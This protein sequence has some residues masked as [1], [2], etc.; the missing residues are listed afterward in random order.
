MPINPKI[1]QIEGKVQ[2][3]DWGGNE[4]IPNLLGL[5]NE[6]RQPFAEYWLGT[7]PSAMSICFDGNTKMALDQYS[8]IPYLFKILDV[9]AMLSIQVHPSKNEAELGFELEN[10][11]GIE[12]TANH[13]NYKD[14]NHKPEMAIAISDFWLLHGFKSKEA[15]VELLNATPEFSIFL[16]VF[17]N[18]NYAELYSFVMNLNQDIVNEILAP[19]MSRIVPD[20]ESGKF[21][22]NEEH[23]WA[24]KAAMSFNKN[25]V[26][27][28]GIF[29]IYFFNLVYLRKGEGIAQL[30]GV[31]HAYLSG[32]CA[33]IMA[34][35]DNV[36]R[37]GLTAKHIDTDELLKIVKSE[38]T[39]PKVLNGNYKGKEL[40]YPSSVEDFRISFFELKGEDIEEITSMGTEIVF[41]LKG[42]VKL[43]VED[44]MVEL[45]QG[46]AAVIFSKQNVIVSAVE[47][48]E[49]FRVSGNNE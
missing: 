1:F 10:Q 26:I 6:N 2:H 14:R 7:H 22:K 48:T 43:E 36:L 15:L 3:Y 39:I 24:A 46:Q 34:N 20:Y 18:G 23:Y 9:R 45:K 29:S 21:T 33:E 49:I 13:R 5:I 31:P 25:G 30:A 19:L 27:D 32:Q 17:N 37:A 8:K 42:S 40:I 41:I 44:K 12:M 11:A 16:T 28:R 35:S 4:F 47:S 38:P